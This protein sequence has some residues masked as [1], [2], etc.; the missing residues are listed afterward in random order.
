MR[1]ETLMTWRYRH[2]TLEE[3]G[4]EAVSGDAADPDGDGKSNLLEFALAGDPRGAEFETGLTL[5]KSP[6]PRYIRITYRR[7]RDRLLSG[8][9]SRLV[10]SS[11]ALHP[12]VNLTV[13]C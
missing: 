12:F 10:T 7:Q 9:S 1:V 6:T 4:T 2:F 5:E 8:I 11:L 13:V 3:L